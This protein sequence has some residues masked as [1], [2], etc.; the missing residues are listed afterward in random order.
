MEVSASASATPAG[1]ATG[2]PDGSSDPAF[3]RQ[4]G[5]AERGFLQLSGIAGNHGALVAV[6]CF[7]GVAEG[8][9]TASGLSTDQRHWIRNRLGFCDA[10]SQ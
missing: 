6:R 4:S 5:K 8:M 2:P 3:Q 1:R 7:P 10:E 9:A